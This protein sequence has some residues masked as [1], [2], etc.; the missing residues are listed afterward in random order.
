[1][2]VT[3][4]ARQAN[5]SRYAGGNEIEHYTL[6]P[7][8]ALRL[9]LAASLLRTEWARLNPTRSMPLVVEIGSSSGNFCERLAEYGMR[10]VA[11]DADI[12]ALR[13]ARGKGISAV[14]L[15]ATE[16]FPFK[17]ESIDSILAGEL[18]EHLYDPL[19]FLSE[20]RR[21]LQP[22]GILV[23]T[24]PNLAALQDR[25]TFLIGRS[26]R[27][28][29]CHHEYLRLHIRP[30]TKTSLQKTVRSA[31]FEPLGVLSNYLV[32]HTA[33]RRFSSRW[34]ARLFPGLGGSLVIAAR[35][36]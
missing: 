12:E 26:P 36:V 18:I 19:I 15:D 33:S 29:D 17:S 20:C 22:D 28:V 24:T 10:P 8:H 1:M 11:A 32:W 23:L 6:D 3:R 9:R 5:V 21:V 4:K 13:V 27:H 35:P 34:L 2:D 7:Y 14:Q 25:L 31:G 30:F 16:P